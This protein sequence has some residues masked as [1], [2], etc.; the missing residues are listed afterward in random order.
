MTRPARTIGGAAVAAV[1]VGILVNALA[2]QKERH[3]AAFVTPPKQAQVA[4]AVE[5]PAPAP[6]VAVQESAPVDIQPPAR[7]ANLGAET[8]G[9][10]HANDPIRDLLRGDPGKD[11][12]VKHLTLSAQNALIKLGYAVKANGVAGPSTQQSIREFERAH[13]QTPTG[14]VTPKLVRQLAAAAAPH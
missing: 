6:A 1:L 3:P 12:D 2:L 13:G 10:V 9:S 5:P 14:E 8:T 11:S 4:P 7:P